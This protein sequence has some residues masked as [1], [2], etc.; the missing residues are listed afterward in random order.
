MSKEFTIGENYKLKIGI[1]NTSDHR[2]YLNIFIKNTSTNE[3]YNSNFDF[4]YM[5]T[6]A[7]FKCLNLQIILSILIEQ[8]EQL[9]A[10]VKINSNKK[11]EMQLNIALNKNDEELQLIIPK[12]EKNEQIDKEEFLKLKTLCSNLLFKINGCFI[13]DE[14]FGDNI[15]NY[16]F[17][18][19]IIKDINEMDLIL[20]AI[21]KAPNMKL[22]V[23]LL[24]TPTLEENSWR[25]FHK[26]CDEKGP[27]IILC[28]SITGKRFGGYTSVSWD[29][30][31][32]GYA[33]NYAFLFS[34]DNKKIY[35]KGTNKGIY[36][37]NNHGIIFRGADLAL[38]E[39]EDG[40]FIGEKQSS[41]FTKN[42][43]CF[44]VPVN[45]LSGAEKFTLKEMEVYQ[46]IFENN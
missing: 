24:Y 41:H 23:K 36:C 31:N 6:K 9:K 45:E 39:N 34:L 37:G 33:D 15:K 1:I 35:N 22:K 11:D 26:Y 2:E 16:G 19:K 12:Y 28:E 27:T 18:N 44:K 10:R 40:T 43:E 25:D 32:V 4:D 29:L 5:K 13:S 46:V 30:K 7:F 42:S 21:Q 14:G 17:T 20:T 3:E 8:L 38:I